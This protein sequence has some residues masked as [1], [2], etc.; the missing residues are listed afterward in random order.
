MERSARFWKLL[1]SLVR[2]ISKDTG[3]RTSAGPFFGRSTISQHAIVWDDLCS[4]PILPV[5]GLWRS[6]CK[7]YAAGVCVLVSKFHHSVRT[8]WLAG[9]AP[10]SQADKGVP[11]SYLN[12]CYNIVQRW[13]K[14]APW[15]HGLR[16][17]TS[18]TG[19]TLTSNAQFL[20]AYTRRKAIKYDQFNSDII[21]SI[22][23]LV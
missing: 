15:D 23:L 20:N 6:T 10:H 22:S 9:H 19:K 11:N 17:Q 21:A 13:N 7:P 14:P 1:H 8:P 16:R 12:I 18:Q 3:D 4:E 5:A 2:H